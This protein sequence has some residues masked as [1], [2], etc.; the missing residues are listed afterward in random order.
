MSNVRH[1][2]MYRRTGAQG[3]AAARD[4]RVQ[5]E[6][7]D[8]D[9]LDPDPLADVIGAL[10]N[11]ALGAALWILLVAALIFGPVIAQRFF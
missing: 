4:G 5:R 8:A 1:L 10:A 6:S 9:A 11:A 2:S 7:R 3:S